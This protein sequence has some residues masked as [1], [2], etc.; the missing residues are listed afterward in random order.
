MRFPDIWWSKEPSL[1][2]GP[3]LIVIMSSPQ[4]HSNISGYEMKNNFPQGYDHKMTP[5]LGSK[6]WIPAEGMLKSVKPII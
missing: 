2:Q 1:S 6:N 5:N 4:I 3:R